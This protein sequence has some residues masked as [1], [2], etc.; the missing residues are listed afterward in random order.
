MKDELRQLL[1]DLKKRWVDTKNV[2]AGWFTT[3][4]SR[5]SVAVPFFMRA[6]DELMKF[7]DRF[8]I[9]GLSKKAV[10]MEAVNELYDTVI[11]PIMPIYLKPFGGIIRELVVDVVISAFVDFVVARVREVL[12]P[13]APTAKASV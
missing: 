3:T 11:V 1:D 12:P 2:K 10:V 5:F 13:P 8:K 7:M 9:P 6:I 4:V